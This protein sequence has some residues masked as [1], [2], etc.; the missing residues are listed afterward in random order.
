MTDAYVIAEQSGAD[1]FSLTVGIAVAFLANNKPDPAAVPHTPDSYRERFGLSAGYRMVAPA[2]SA[3]R[4][5]HA[6][7]SAAGARAR[8]PAKATKAAG[9]PRT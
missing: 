2:Y 3:V 7:A 9:R 1:L 5:A 8:L 6:K 4:S